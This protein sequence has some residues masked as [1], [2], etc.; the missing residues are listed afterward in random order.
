MQRST[1]VGLGLGRLNHARVLE[2]TPAIRGMIHK[3]N[4]L[5]VVLPVENVPD[6]NAGHTSGRRFGIKGGTLPRRLGEAGST[7]HHP[8]AAE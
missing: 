1:L 6:L 7:V 4:H 8:I 5:V 2:D 3:V